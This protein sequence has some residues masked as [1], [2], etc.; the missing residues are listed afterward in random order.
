MYANYISVNRVVTYK[1]YHEV[2]DNMLLSLANPIR[3][4]DQVKRFLELDFE[5]VIDIRVNP[6]K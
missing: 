3:N 2:R 1:G 6:T 5:H 4:I